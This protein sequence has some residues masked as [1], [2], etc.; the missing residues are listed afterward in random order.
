MITSK[1]A[2]FVIE[3]PGSAPRELVPDYGIGLKKET[4]GF[5]GDQSCALVRIAFEQL[6]HPVGRFPMVV[7][8]GAPGNGKTLLAYGAARLLGGTAEQPVP[9]LAG[10][11]FARQ[12][13]LACETNS[14]AEFR[15]RFRQWPALIVDDVDRIRSSMAQEELVFLLDYFLSGNRP[16]VVTCRSDQQWEGRAASALASRLSGGLS[17][18][19]GR[20]GHEGLV[21]LACWIAQRAG[22]ALSERIAERLV[23][24]FL[25][26]RPGPLARISST[27]DF[28]QFLIESLKRLLLERVSLDQALRDYDRYS[29][30]TQPSIRAVA[31]KVAQF[32]RV[33][34]AQ[35][36]GPGRQRHL[37]SARRVAMYLARQLTNKTLQQIGAFFTG[38]DHTTVLY[39]CRQVDQRLAHDPHLE[40]I[41][42][43]ISRE[44]L[45][46]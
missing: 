12:C 34:L 36:R 38:R 28:L 40:E 30:T 18:P 2:G 21:L 14:L 35:L 32:Y 7:L 8:N 1:A 37:A 23:Q 11:R 19:V 44:L 29:G 4:W 43:R 9:V 20:P 16:V 22:C 13:G 42:C 25:A 27:R 10:T 3:F 45:D 26:S 39:A 31:E 33:P 6:T 41:I 5:V 15:H 24:S 46:S 17:V